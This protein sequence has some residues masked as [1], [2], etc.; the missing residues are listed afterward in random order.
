M[1]GTARATAAAVGSILFASACHRHATPEEC[2]AAADRYVDLAARES[3][4]AAAMSAA[5]LAAVRDVERGL[6]RAEP[7]F[8]SLQDRCPDAIRTEVSCAADSVTT[9]AW[10]GCFHDAGPGAR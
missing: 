4:G 5:Q 8:R 3:P 7:A 10:E 2:A 9:A 6:K 1:N